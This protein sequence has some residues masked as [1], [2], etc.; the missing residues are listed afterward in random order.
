ML[1]T[2]RVPEDVGRGPASEVRAPATLIYDAEC[3]FCQRWV[4]RLKR[5]DR[6]S[7]TRLLPLQD[8]QAVGLSGRTRDQ[9]EAAIHLIRP[10]GSVFDGADAAHELLSLIWWG[11]LPRTVLRVPGA[12]PLA[13]RLYRWVAARRRGFGCGGD[14]CRLSVAGAADDGYVSG[15]TKEGDRG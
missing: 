15:K 7:E 5:L 13:R 4:A 9:L 10:D 1:A 6:R 3:A 11:W 2:S 12:M 8:E 14:H